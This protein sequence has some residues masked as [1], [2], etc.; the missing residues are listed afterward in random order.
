M[1]DKQQELFDYI[2]NELGVHLSLGQMLD[3]IIIVSKQEDNSHSFCETPDEN[4]T[5]NY[6]DDN[7]CN[8]RKRSCVDPKPVISEE[9]CNPNPNTSSS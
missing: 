3:I 8:N 2:S 6:C 5:M 9:Q 1:K 7:G 4:C